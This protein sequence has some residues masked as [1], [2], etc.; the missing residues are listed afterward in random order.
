MITSPYRIDPVSPA[1]PSKPKE[2][3]I[4][5]LEGV[6]PG[7]PGTGTPSAPTSGGEGIGKGGAS[8]DQAAAQYLVKLGKLLPADVT[9]LYLTFYGQGA[10]NAGFRMAWPTICLLVTV[11]L[12][13]WGTREPGASAFK[14]VKTA[15]WGVVIVTGVSFV[16]WVLAAGHPFA[17]F[18][19]SAADQIWVAAGVAV[20][21]LILPI[22]YG[23]R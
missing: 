23:R 22:F 15:Q 2:S 8:A 12:R 1:P 4:S 13:I 9:S 5:T 10:T 18:E 19:V 14:S 17:G 11:L 16:L 3:E 20:W 6:T 21:T 7:T